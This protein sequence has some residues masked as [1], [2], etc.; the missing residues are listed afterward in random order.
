MTAPSR[1]RESSQ[2][3]TDASVGRPLQLDYSKVRGYWGR[4]KPSMLGPYMMEGFGFP[5][6]AGRFRFRG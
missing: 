6:G 1:C 3:K 5:A 4:A 2:S